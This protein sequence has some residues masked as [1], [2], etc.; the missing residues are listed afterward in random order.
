[1][2]SANKPYF[3]MYQKDD[4]YKI[5]RTDYIDAT[6]FNFSK[7]KLIIKSDVFPENY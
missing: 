7:N 4:N 1:M 5:H 2:K 3:M 6:S